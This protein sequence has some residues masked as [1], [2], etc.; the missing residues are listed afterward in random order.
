MS[1]LTSPEDV[2]NDSNPRAQARPSPLQWLFQESKTIEF[3]STPESREPASRM[4]EKC[5]D[6][7]RADRILRSIHAGL[8]VFLYSKKQA[9]SAGFWRLG[10]RSALS[11]PGPR[12]RARSA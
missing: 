8:Q 4:K 7:P 11:N 6:G 5:R 10:R 9:I 12:S 2:E 3:L 1:R